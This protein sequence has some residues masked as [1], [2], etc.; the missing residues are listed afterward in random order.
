[1]PATY[2]PDKTVNYELGYKGAF[3]DRRL[4]L[5][6]ALFY[7][8][9]TNIQLTALNEYDE[10]FTVN[11]NKARSQGAQFSGQYLSAMASP[12]SSPSPT[13]MPR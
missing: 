1:M 13:P 6:T 12:R 3:L 8:D 10:G 11:G 2:G 4:E 9:W 7:I 5:E